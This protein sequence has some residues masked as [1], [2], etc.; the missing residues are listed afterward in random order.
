MRY[1]T[2]R[3]SFGATAFTR[4]QH[5]AIRFLPVSSMLL[6]PLN[7]GESRAQGIEADCTFMLSPG[8][9]ANASYALTN[10]EYTHSGIDFTQ[11]P[12]NRFS[13]AVGYESN[14][15]AGR[16]S[17]HCESSQSSD[18]FGSVRVPAQERLDVT[19]SRKAG[20]GRLELAVSNLLDGYNRDYWDLPL[21]GRAFEI[22]WSQRF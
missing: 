18:L 6:K 16:A 2:K 4:T 21:P 12:R 20:K 14:D 1:E 19:V 22:K 5:D 13:C 15:W 11:T 3:A 10:A 17:L 7:T 9:T 8:L